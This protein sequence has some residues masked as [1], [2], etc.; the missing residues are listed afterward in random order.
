MAENPEIKDGLQENSALQTGGNSGS[1]VQESTTK[2]KS[3][4]PLINNSEAGLLDQSKSVLPSWKNDDKVI[5]PY[6]TVEEFEADIEQLDLALNSS[7][8]A[9]AKRSPNSGLLTLLNAKIDEHISYVKH[10]LELE[11]GKKLVKQNYPSLGVEHIRQSYKIPFKTPQRRVAL[12]MLGNTL[13]T[14]N[15]TDQYCT[16]EFWQGLIDEFNSLTVDSVD[17]VKVASSFTGDKT[18]L[19]NKVRKVLKS[20]ATILTGQYPDTYESVLR[21]WGFLREKN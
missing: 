21:S 2:N 3:R 20:I 13:K 10:R 11:V 5:L 6:I 4:A 18:M 16:V 7:T 8:K 19:K 17:D 14:Y 15:W 1:N 9:K 12:T